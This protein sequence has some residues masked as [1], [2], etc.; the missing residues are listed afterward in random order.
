MDGPS[1]EKNTVILFFSQKGPAYEKSSKYI[2]NDNDNKQNQEDKYKY[3]L[4]Q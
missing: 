4:L 2:D 3:Y 1:Y